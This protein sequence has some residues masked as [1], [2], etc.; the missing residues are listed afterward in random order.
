[1]TSPAI[2]YTWI[3]E[4]IQTVPSENGLT[5]VIKDIHWRVN[6][7]A[8]DNISA[9][10]YGSTGLES[11][12]PEDFVSYPN[13]TESTVIGWLQTTLGEETVTNIQ[14]NL[15]GEIELKRNPPV[16]IKPVPW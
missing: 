16:E 13:L 14:T 12:D 2:T 11:P 4:Q 3:I 7:L 10:S 9:T 1:M 8:A 15:A 5:D 6:A